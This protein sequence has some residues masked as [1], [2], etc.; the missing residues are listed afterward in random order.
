[1]FEIIK[2]LNE[3]SLHYGQTI[4]GVDQ[5]SSNMGQTLGVLQEGVECVRHTTSK[6]HQLV[7]RFRVSAANSEAA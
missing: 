2:G 4:R 7:G 3:R 6:L 5:A 1:M